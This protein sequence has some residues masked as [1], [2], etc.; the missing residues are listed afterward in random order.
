M[1]SEKRYA[2][3]KD[4]HIEDFQLARAMKEGDESALERFINK[5]RTYV[6]NCAAVRLN[7]HRDAQDLTIKIFEKVW[8][9][10]IPRW[11]VQSGCFTSYFKRMAHWY[12]GNEVNRL[13]KVAARAEMVS[14]DD[15]D[16]PM[17]LPDT[18]TAHDELMAELKGETI[19]E[20][21]EIALWKVQIK[22]K[23]RKLRIWR[24]RHRRGMLAREIA[25][26]LNIPSLK[27]SQS[28]SQVN[29]KLRDLLNFDAL[30]NDSVEVF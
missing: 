2:K 13:Q 16:N 28:I 12:I 15:D 17:T 18:T 30:M 27:V 19:T 25:E 26:E 10:L 6:L 11:D 9:Y 1:Y 8:S 21:I 23:R 3:Q 20:A 7:D 5:H 22:D 29:L 14:I 4:T 24:M